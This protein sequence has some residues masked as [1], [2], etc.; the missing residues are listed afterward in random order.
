[1]RQEII[2]SLLCGSVCLSALSGELRG[3]RPGSGLHVKHSS[4]H[5]NIKKQ[6]GAISDGPF[7]ISKEFK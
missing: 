4:S 7:Q 1:M 6:V 3:A 5:R 2:L